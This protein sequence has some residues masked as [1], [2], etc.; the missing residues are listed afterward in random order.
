MRKEKRGG[1]GEEKE[2]G[3]GKAAKIH[4]IQL[5]SA[6]TIYLY[7]RHRKRVILRS[8]PSQILDKRIISA[9]STIVNCQLG[10][11]NA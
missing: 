10:N 1:G 9:N 5:T 6:S 3:R 2:E 7:W 11:K 8:T 4:L